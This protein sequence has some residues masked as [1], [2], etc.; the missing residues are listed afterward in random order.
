[1]S[2][3]RMKRSEDRVLTT[4]AGSLP[5]PADLLAMTPGQPGHAERVRGAVAE[6]VRRQAECGLDV[7]TDGARLGSRRLWDR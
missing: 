6:A 4:H 5:R 2:A 3:P 1:M 7:V